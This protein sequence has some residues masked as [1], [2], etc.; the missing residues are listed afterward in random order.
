MEPFDTTTFVFEIINFLVLIWILQHFFYKPIRNVISRRQ[1]AIQASIDQA[2][3]LEAEAQSLRGRYE[4]RLEDWEQ[5]KAV[6]RRD[7]KNEMIA[8]RERA[9]AEIAAELA[10][11]REKAEAIEAKRRVDYQ[12]HYQRLCMAQSAR[13]A[14][15]LLGELAGPELEGRLFRMALSRLDALPA[16][17]LDGLRIACEATP[18]EAQVVTA[19]HLAP[20]DRVQLQ[21]RLDQVL[22]MPVRCRYR[23]DPALL[24]GL[25][26]TLGPWVFQAN[27]RDE[28]AAFVDAADGHV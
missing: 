24:A 23:Q 7:F 1:T 12:R 11:E 4:G 5:E 25:S 8:A 14:A 9:L 27:L 20:D 10:G 2:R 16:A 18:E 28:L 13:F 15:R 17:T 6:G 21:Q 3:T 19:Y 26:V 22:G